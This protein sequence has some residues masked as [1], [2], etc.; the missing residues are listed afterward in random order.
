MEVKWPVLRD[1]EELFL[2]LELR[3]EKLTFSIVK[4]GKTDFFPQEKRLAAIRANLQIK[5]GH[6]P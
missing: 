6:S 4:G 3:E 5:E 1:G 2:I